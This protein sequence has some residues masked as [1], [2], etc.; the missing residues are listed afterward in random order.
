MF[1][2]CWKRKWQHFVRDGGNKYVMRFLSIFINFAIVVMVFGAVLAHVRKNPA[3]LVFRYFTV[4]SNVFCALACMVF[5]ISR[6]VGDVSEAIYVL[7]YVGTVAVM[8]TF[9]TVM[10]FLGPKE[11]TY[12]NLMSGPDLYLHLICPIAALV[13]YIFLDGTRMSIWAVICGMLPVILYGIL[14]LKKVVFTD[15]DRAWD[16][17]YGFNVDGK[18]KLSFLLMVAATAILSFVLYIIV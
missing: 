15:G 13:S 5:A 8:V 7:R 6:I 1:T 10:L 16:D 11:G 2:G 14:Y 3:H 17:F 18:W 9:L 4:Q 12:K